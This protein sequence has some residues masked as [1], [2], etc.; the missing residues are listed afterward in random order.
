V[1][2]TFKLS[3][4]LTF[5]FAQLDTVRKLSAQPVPWFGIFKTR[6]LQTAGFAPGAQL[7]VST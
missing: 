3:T 2:P 6:Q 4:E 1:A 7:T 5:K